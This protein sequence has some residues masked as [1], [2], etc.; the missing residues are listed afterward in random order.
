[1]KTFFNGLSGVSYIEV[2]YTNPSTNPVANASTCVLRIAFGKA[3]A[4]VEVGATSVVLA[5]R[6]VLVQ[7]IYLIS[8]PLFIT[9]KR[10]TFSSAGLFSLPLSLEEV[11]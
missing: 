4:D 6:H 11:T 8:E 3:W 10:F 9:G 2:I 5:Y 7:L 1:M